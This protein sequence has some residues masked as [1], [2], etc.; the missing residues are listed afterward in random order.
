MPG[1]GEHLPEPPRAPTSALGQSCA[2]CTT[3]DVAWVHPLAPDRVAFRLQ[4]T[5]HTLPTFWMLC[6]RCEAIYL[7]A[8]DDAAVAAMRPSAGPLPVADE[9]DRATLEVFRRADLGP[10]RLDPEPAALAEA[11][12]RGFLPLDDLTGIAGTL[13]PLWPAEHRL[14]LELAVDDEGWLVRSPWPSF[15]VDE[16]LG[17]VWRWVERAPYPADDEAWEARMREVLRW[18]EHE[19]LTFSASGA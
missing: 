17:L 11:R 13:G 4:G 14:R 1:R 5:S 10:R 18:S 7:T 8:D 12:A 6:E 2:W 16:A 19:A 3:R 9:H 15:S